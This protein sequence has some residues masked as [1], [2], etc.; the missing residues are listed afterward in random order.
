MEYSLTITR[1]CS[2]QCPIQYYM[3]HFQKFVAPAYDEA[4]IYQYIHSCVHI[5][6]YATATDHNIFWMHVLYMLLD[7][8]P[9]FYMCTT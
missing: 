9:T 8:T 4:I 6:T 5:H 3:D 7:F 2:I 1:E